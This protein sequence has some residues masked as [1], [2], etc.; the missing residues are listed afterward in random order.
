M[1]SPIVEYDDEGRY[2]GFAGVNRR[3]PEPEYRPRYAVQQ[4]PPPYVRFD[5]EQQA[6]GFAGVNW[7]YAEPI[8]GD[9]ESV[10]QG[11][12]IKAKLRWKM[13]KLRRGKNAEPWDTFLNRSL[14]PGETPWAPEDS[15]V[16][17]VPKT[18]D[19]SEPAGGR[20]SSV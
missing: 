8:L 14:K 4:A 19:V 18:T 12:V 7:S 1:R 17:K 2:L 20:R 5:N 6:L 10:T 13:H 9:I 15:P 3:F 16:W 11:D